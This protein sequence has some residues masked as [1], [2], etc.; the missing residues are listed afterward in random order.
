M[1]E[2]RQYATMAQ[3]V[4]ES[5][6]SVFWNEERGYLNDT[7]R[8]DGTIDASLRPNQIFAV[9]LPYG[10]PLK[11]S[12]QRA[13]VSVVEKALLTPYGLR[14]LD[15]RDESYMGRYEGPQWQ[16]DGAYHQGTAWPYLMGPFVE[17]YLK[18]HDFKP[19]S[20][21][22]AAEMIGPLLRHLTIDGCLG[23][24]AEVFDGDDPQRPA[25]CPA[26]AWSVGELLRIYQLLQNGRA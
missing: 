14:T 8:P 7:I 2:A 17:A 13:I 1:A 10:P 24:I 15:R 21:K 18:V 19:A 22:Q 12:R 9:S 25:G 20:K 16:R 5:F 4:G 3:Q 23:S 11:R 6:C 26:Q